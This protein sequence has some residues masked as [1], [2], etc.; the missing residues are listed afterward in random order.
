MK[1]L[2][3]CILFLVVCL[4]EAGAA[5]LF[6]STTG[7]DTNSGTLSQPFATVQKAAD[8]AAA[9]DTVNIRGG[10]YHES[11][12]IDG[13]VGSETNR[14]VFQNYN[15]EA[16]VIAG[17]IPITNSWMQW[18]QNTNVWKT[19]V[20]EDIWQLFVDDKAMTGARWP[21]VQKDWM[22]PDS[23]DGHNPTPFSFWDQQTT[24]AKITDASSW[25][26]MV[27]DDLKFDLICV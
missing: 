9:G 3:Q 19:T 17:T 10:R 20:S 14:I 27:N 16:V 4:F 1:K 13:L 2:I 8:S 22:E 11:I 7:S 15:D 26:H 6:V 23:G 25:G 24:W 21:N 18:D 12:T 5:A